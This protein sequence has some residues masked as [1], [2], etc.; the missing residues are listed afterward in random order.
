[1]GSLL[2]VDMAIP[3]LGLVLTLA[4]FAA[5]LGTLAQGCLAGAVIVTLDWAA[6]RLLFRAIFAQRTVRSMPRI[7]AVLLLGFKFIF[8]A[9]F[10]YLII[11]FFGFDPYGMA[12]GMGSLPAGIVVGSIVEA[13][14]G[15]PKT[16]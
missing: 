6:I 3:V 11:R 9:V 7:L 8:L 2:A 4:L 12:I 13:R 14:R 1:M 15:K 10:I 16:G 5:G